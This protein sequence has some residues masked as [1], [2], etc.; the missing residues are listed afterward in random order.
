MGYRLPLGPPAYC[1][2]EAPSL[3]QDF[4][5]AEMMLPALRRTMRS[6]P[7]FLNKQGQTFM[8]VGGGLDVKSWLIRGLLQE[9]G[10]GL[11]PFGLQLLWVILIKES[12]SRR[13]GEKAE[14][15]VSPWKEAQFCTWG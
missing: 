10:A 12:V 8:R 14:L 2:A 11:A 7:P 1:R 3:P 6:Q 13:E 9:L 4:L 15:F 5:E